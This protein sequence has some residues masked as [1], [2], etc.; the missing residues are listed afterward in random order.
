MFLEVFGR[1]RNRSDAFGYVRIHS[2]ALECAQMHENAMGQFRKI[3]EFRQIFC[4]FDTF[5]KLW[6]LLLLRFER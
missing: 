1:V 5:S 6:A 4:R 3:S 2:D